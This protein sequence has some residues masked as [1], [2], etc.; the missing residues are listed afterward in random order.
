MFISNNRLP[1]HLWSKGN[2]V[3]HQRVSEYYENDCSTEILTE[4]MI[5][6]ILSYF[7]HFLLVGSNDNNLCFKFWNFTIKLFHLL[8]FTK[9]LVFGSSTSATR[10]TLFLCVF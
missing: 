5:Q 2:L 9:E 1:F 7:S 3:K 4:S 10:L 8:G 6:F